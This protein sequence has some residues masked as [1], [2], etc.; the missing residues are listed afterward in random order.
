MS[1]CPFCN[2]LTKT[3]EYLETE[4]GFVPEEV[5]VNENCVHFDKF[6]LTVSDDEKENKWAVEFNNHIFIITAQSAD[7]AITKALQCANI[8]KR[9][10]VISVQS[11]EL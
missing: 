3:A 7:D 6:V 2:H 11:M 5:C 9:P 4:D 1:K 10:S 8:A